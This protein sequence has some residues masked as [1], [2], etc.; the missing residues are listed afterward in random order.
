[1]TKPRPPATPREARYRGLAHYYSGKPCPAGHVAPRYTSNR[2]C[3]VCTRL[4]SREQY[5]A[6]HPGSRIWTVE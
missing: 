1:M 4:T 6:A 5:R 3:T 2:R